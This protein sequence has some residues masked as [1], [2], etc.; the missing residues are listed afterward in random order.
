MRKHIFC[1]TGGLQLVGD[2]IVKE[3]DQIGNTPK[4]RPMECS[5]YWSAYQTSAADDLNF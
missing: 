1:D 5:P 4:Q 2:S 3:A